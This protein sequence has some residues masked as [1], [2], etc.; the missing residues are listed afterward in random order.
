MLELT[1][2]P[3]P[4][5]AYYN[6]NT[7]TTETLSPRHFRCPETSLNA[8]EEGVGGEYRIKQEG[9]N[10][11]RNK[12]KELIQTRKRGSYLVSEIPKTERGTE[13]K[14]KCTERHESTLTNLTTS[15]TP[16]L[17]RS[18]SALASYNCS[19]LLE[20]AMLKSE[21][22]EIRGKLG[23]LPELDMLGDVSGSCRQY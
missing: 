4:N 6:S 8:Q 7:N 12:R 21:R 9:E 14:R 11:Y 15:R 2:V 5:T 17:S 1:R 13:G 16:V 3:L 19:W 18:L 22:V 20:S 23:K 10:K